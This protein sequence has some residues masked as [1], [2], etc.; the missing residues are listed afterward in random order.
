MTARARPGVAMWAGIECT[1]N[2]VG[3]R[4]YDQIARSGHGVRESDLDRIAALGV[5]V[6]RYPLLWERLAPGPGDDVDWAWADRRVGRLRALGLTPVVGLVHHGSGP[7]RTH[8]AD[9][10]FPERL[11]DYAR[12]V[13]ERYPDLDLWTPVNEPLTTARFCGLYG[14]WYPHG[15]DDRTFVRALLHQ[16]QGI[17]RAMAAVRRVV[18]GA[19]LVQTEDLGR[20]HATPRL[21][22]QAEFE[23]HRRWLTFDLLCGRVDHDHPLR[24][25]LVGAGA[26]PAELDRLRDDP[27]PPDVLGLNHYLTSERFLDERLHRY[28]ARTHGGNGRDVYADVE[29]VRVL[30]GGPTGPRA[31]LREV[32]ERYRLP[33]A[34]TEVH[35]GCT[36]EEQ[37]RWLHEVWR[38]ACGARA[39][40]ADVRAVTAWSA[41]GT[42]DWDSLVTRDE[43][44]YEPGLFDVRAPAPR[45]TAVAAMTRAL[46]T[47]GEFH[48]PVLAVPGWW[49]RNDR[50]EFPP[51]PD[52]PGPVRRSEHPVDV[53]D[54]PPILVTGAA[55]TLG[56]AFLRAC[57]RR[58][59]PC[60]ALARVE[61]DVTRQDAVQAALGAVRPWA[62]VNAAGYVRVD[63][64]ERDPERC[65]RENVTG[66]AVLAAACA[67]A[68]VRLLTFS[69]D[70]V[71]DGGLRAPY[72]ERH[73]VAPLGVYGRTKAEAED[74]VLAA[75]P[76]ALVVRTAAFFGPWDDD[77]FLTV[78]LA[79]LRAR[80]PFACADDVVVSPTYVP[81]L[82]SASLDLLID[83]E[84]G[85]WHLA[86]PG[87]ITWADLA[88]RAAGLAGLG[89][90]D[91]HPVAACDLG[92]RAP[93]PAY[94]VLG[95]ERS[96][97]VAGEAGSSLLPSLDDA[98][99]RY[100]EERGIRDP[101]RSTAGRGGSP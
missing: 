56:Q 41:L 82:V 50:L 37:L 12:A 39:E 70:L 11:A 47:A 95:S 30:A 18:P 10:S 45:A 76:G 64:A 35:L 27:C 4:F 69:S 19:R 29:A 99:A 94:S 7:R 38:A 55:G 100:A 62:V 87:A 28:P 34:V 54:A 74:R 59:L 81:D 91:I 101:A 85:I 53:P 31:L 49:R 33:V 80:R 36:R 44:R 88:V 22:R 51:Y 60:R 67:R 61:L 20:T 92:W 8:L 93:R 71:F 97:P 32:W 89:T 65:R 63:D 66:P 15:R 90:A 26:A 21:A 25:W 57:R 23:N 78:A 1:L 98:L 52:T 9:P 84:R 43:G 58:G 68:G 24:A 75:H 86:N 48:H 72:P 79:H 6:V 46:A 42:F 40:G 96:H 77:N 5:R 83:G 3:D 17:A 2:R 16:C 14:H 73:P 13:A